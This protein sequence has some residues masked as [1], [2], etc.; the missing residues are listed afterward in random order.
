MKSGSLVQQ[1]AYALR[2]GDRREATALL[3]QALSD[4]PNDTDAL[5]ASARMS[6]A[7]GQVEES[8]AFARR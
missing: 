8:L 7:S 6:Q 5:I 3:Q 1:A 4:N 2:N